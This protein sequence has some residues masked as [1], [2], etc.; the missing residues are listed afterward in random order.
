MEKIYWIE[1][2]KVVYHVSGMRYDPTIKRYFTWVNEDTD[3][4]RVLFYWPNKVGDFKLVEWE[5]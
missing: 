5:K 3:I 1:D 2:E 4:P